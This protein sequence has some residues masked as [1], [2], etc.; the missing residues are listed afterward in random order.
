MHAELFLTPDV[1]HTVG[2]LMELS[3]YSP[4]LPHASQVIL[5]SCWPRQPHVLPAP[6]AYVENEGDDRE[7]TS[8]R[9][10]HD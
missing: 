2:S 3:Q 6:F 7:L 8:L 1:A 4:P 5:F 9:L 10:S